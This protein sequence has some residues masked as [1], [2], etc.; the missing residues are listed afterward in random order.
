[1][2]SAYHARTDLALLQEE[3]KV[4]LSITGKLNDQL[5][6]LKVRLCGRIKLDKRNLNF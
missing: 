6:R 3:E 5:N 4:L 1:M 2:S